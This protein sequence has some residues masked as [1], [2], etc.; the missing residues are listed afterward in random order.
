MPARASCRGAGPNA[1]YIGMDVH[2]ATVCMA[3]AESGRRGRCDTSGC[4][5]R[6]LRNIVE[7]AGPVVRA[8]S[9]P[10][11]GRQAEGRSHHCDRPRGGRRHLGNRPQ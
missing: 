1:R 3:L 6:G 9:A 4:S 11:R 8:I 2:K 10:G 7:S 5:S